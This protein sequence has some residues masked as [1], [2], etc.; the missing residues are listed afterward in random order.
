MSTTDRICQHLQAIDIPSKEAS[1]YASLIGKWISN[2]GP[3]WTVQRLKSLKQVMKGQLESNPLGSD[4]TVPMGF[5]T[6]KNRRG[7]VIFSDGLLHRMF[8]RPKT[9]KTLRQLEAFIRVYQVIK[10]FDKLHCK[11]R[12]KTDN[13]KPVMMTASQKEKFLSAVVSPQSVEQSLFTEV[14]A[15]RL[16]QLGIRKPG[17][18]TL[19]ECA[20]QDQVSKPLYRFIGGE[21]MA[22]AFDID[23]KDRL[24][25]LGSKSRGDPM[26]YDF[27]PMLSD[28][29]MRDLWS[30]YSKEFSIRMTGRDTYPLA[31]YSGTNV[32]FPAGK[33]AVIQEGGCKARWIANPY[34][35]FQA[36]LEPLKN[37]LNKFSINCYPEIKTTDPEGAYSKVSQWLESRRTVY[38]FDSS[39]FTDRF[40]LRLQMSVMQ[41]LKKEGVI[42]SFDYD[43]FSAIVKKSYLPFEGLGSDNIKWTVG[44]PLGLGPSFHLATLTHA[45]V[46]ELLKDQTLGRQNTGEVDYM[47]VGDDIV[48]ADEHL[49]I[50]YKELMTSLGVEINLSKSMI[51]PNYAEFLGKIISEDGV[52][53]ST[54]VSLIKDDPDAIID[55]LEFYGR[56]GLLCLNRV[57]TAL[58]VKSIWPENF[59]GLGWRPE[60][61]SYSSY[62]SVLNRSGA[63][64]KG[65]K[66]EL[67]NFHGTDLTVDSSKSDLAAY[68]HAV[69]DF[70]DLI[71]LGLS[72]SEW[73]RILGDN[74]INELTRIPASDSI[75]GDLQQMVPV[76]YSRFNQFIS[77][78][79]SHT[80]QKGFV[81]G[82]HYPE[83]GKYGYAS[84]EGSI[85]PVEKQS[86]IS[87]N[88]PT[89][90]EQ[91]HE[92]IRKHERAPSQPQNQKWRGI[93]K[94]GREI[95]REIARSSAGRFDTAKHAIESQERK[96]EGGE[97]VRPKESVRHGSAG[98]TKIKEEK[99]KA[100]KRGGPTCG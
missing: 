90:K 14:V 75:V 7:R 19:V 22:P 79:D 29:V 51:S 84:Q 1:R 85:Q 35:P 77:I 36:L 62:L 32:D 6:K 21:K 95:K 69:R 10:V 28:P 58:S 13:G 72:K 63:Q 68:L 3:E 11:V 25:Y 89:V 64:L 44:Q 50:A 16:N 48:I 86:T 59:G 57:Q 88:L 76:S 61:L 60:E 73:E 33:V 24:V 83:L 96:L 46:L 37:K 42:N 18:H 31:Y 74:P 34:M 54:K 81:K 17:Y 30:K 66:Q 49:A 87:A 92:S 15:E 4:Y 98:S 94:I 47:I 55:L 27:R 38:C 93:F 53:P 56:R 65:L 26:N 43:C 52:S 5:A 99:P 40:P 2:S 70:F 100:S 39:S 23:Y 9:P 71:D 20:R 80:K 82:H 41:H 8:A 12:P 67:E 97:G 78:V 91:T 45:C